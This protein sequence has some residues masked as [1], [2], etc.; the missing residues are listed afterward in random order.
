MTTPPMRCTHCDAPATHHIRCSDGKL[1]KQ[2]YS[3]ADGTRSLLALCEKHALE[4]M[5]LNAATGLRWTT[6][7]IWEENHD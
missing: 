4:F 5:E 3:N 2:P 1:V 7:P 6:E